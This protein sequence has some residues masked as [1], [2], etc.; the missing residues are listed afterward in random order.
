[1]KK[2]N[3]VLVGVA[4]SAMILVGTTVYIHTRPA[5]TAKSL[6]YGMTYADAKRMP[7]ATKCLEKNSTLTISAGDRSTV[8]QVAMLHLY[9]VPAGTNVDVLIAS[10]AK[11]RVTG[12]EHY[13][14]K[15][16]SYNFAMGKQSNGDWQFTKF[17]HCY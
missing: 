6:S 9:D 2:Q 5:A 12:S 17:E 10:Y 11:D 8:E 1:M 7:L 3:I 4:L 13:P 14:A 15:Y 16:G